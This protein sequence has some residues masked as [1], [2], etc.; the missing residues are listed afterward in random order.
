MKKKNPKREWLR[1]VHERTRMEARDE[2]KGTEK[3]FREKKIVQGLRVL[4][5]HIQ[6][7][8]RKKHN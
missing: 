5:S 6:S 8:L 4:S 1:K 7:L 2:D 3:I